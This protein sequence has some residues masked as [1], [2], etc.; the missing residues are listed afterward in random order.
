MGIVMRAVASLLMLLVADAA[1]AQSDPAPLKMWL[2]LGASR[3]RQGEPVAAVAFSPDGKY[4][5]TVTHRHAAWPWDAQSGEILARLGAGAL[6]QTVAFAADSKTVY[7]GNRDGVIVAYA[8]SAKHE[9]RETARWTEGY[10]A[11]M[12]LH[13]PADGALLSVTENRC[14]TR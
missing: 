7:L 6:A 2:Q 10:H 11:V 14:V 4:L 1:V 5:A 12:H 8:V 3:F 9:V 13:C